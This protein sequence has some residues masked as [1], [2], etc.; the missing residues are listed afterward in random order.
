L[1]GTVEI[2]QLLQARDDITEIV[3]KRLIGVEGPVNERY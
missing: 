3:E 1:I 2:D